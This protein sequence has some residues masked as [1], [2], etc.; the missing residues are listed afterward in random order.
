M[1][2]IRSYKMLY[3]NGFA[4]NPY[5]G[6]LTLATCKPYIR[7]VHKI[8]QWLA[9]FA[10]VNIEKKRFEYVVGAEPLIFLALI[11][12]KIEFKKYYLQYPQKRDELC[13]NSDNIY[14]W[15]DSAYQRQITKHKFHNSIADMQKDINPPY[16]LIADEFY[17]FGGKAVNVPANIRPNVPKNQAPYGCVTEGELMDKFI[18]WVREQAAQFPAKMGILAQPHDTVEMCGAIISY[19]SAKG[20]K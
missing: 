15:V 4:P 3:D 13:P 9:G 19:N 12:N 8:G 5:A 14:K 18:A 7:K 11:N 20:C 16:C 10:G 17:Y 1:T 6:C 2:E